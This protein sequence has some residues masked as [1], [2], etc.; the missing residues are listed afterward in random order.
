L[1]ERIRQ[2]RHIATEISRKIIFS[3]TPYQRFVAA[4]ER[5]PQ[6]QQ[7]IET[8]LLLH[9]I[10]RFAVKLRGGAIAEGNV[11][12]DATHQLASFHERVIV[13]VA[14]IQFEIVIRIPCDTPIHDQIGI[15]IQAV[16]APSGKS[17]HGKSVEVELAFHG[18][19]SLLHA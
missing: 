10:A 12:V 13:S 3:I 16:P 18:S 9:V 4:T 14:D 8:L 5:K 7:E 2:I 19:D 17:L 1:R 15:A 11:V 6:P